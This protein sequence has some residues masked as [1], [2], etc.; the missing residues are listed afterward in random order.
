MLSMS[1]LSNMLKGNDIFISQLYSIENICTVLECV[2]KDMS[3]YVYVQSKYEFD[4]SNS[5]SW[6]LTELSNDTEYTH[7]DDV[8][9]QKVTLD[10]SDMNQEKTEDNLVEKYDQKVDL[11]NSR[12]SKK[13]VTQLEKILKRLNKPLS[14]TPYGLTIMYKNILG[15][16]HYDGESLLFYRINNFKNTTDK[17]RLFVNID[18][19]QLYVNSSRIYEDISI[20]KTSLRTILQENIFRNMSNVSDVSIKNVRFNEKVYMR[21]YFELTN[22]I[23]KVT[24]ILTNLT[25]SKEELKEEMEYLRQNENMTNIHHIGKLEQE[26]KDIVQNE[27]EHRRELQRMNNDI[28]HFLILLDK[29]CFDIYV[30]KRMIKKRFFELENLT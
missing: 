11:T 5:R 6:D 15:V 9:R 24:N 23:E 21:K 27:E 29:I 26:F 7:E 19:E 12:T 20:I 2:I 13:I 28:D 18:L 4:T 16:S 17:Y 8:D 10:N 14:E 1:K 30:M 3:F 22:R 25:T